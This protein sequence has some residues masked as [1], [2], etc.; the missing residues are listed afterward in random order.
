MELVPGISRKSAGVSEPDGISPSLSPSE[1]ESPSLHF[2]GL[3]MGPGNVKLSLSRLGT[4]NEFVRT[5]Y[6]IPSFH[7]LRRISIQMGIQDVGTVSQ[8][9]I[10]RRTQRRRLERI[11]FGGSAESDVQRARGSLPRARFTQRRRFLAL[12][13]FPRRGVL[14]GPRGH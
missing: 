1:V 3:R 10:R 11:D 13:T 7:R 8:V 12:E 6:L 2:S 5:W 9:I 4:D 14:N